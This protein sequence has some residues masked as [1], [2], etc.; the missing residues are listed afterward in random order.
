MAQ[1]KFFDRNTIL[2]VGFILA[3]LLGLALF[4]TC[5][6]PK[7]REVKASVVTSETEV[8]VGSPIIFQDNTEE[9][10]T[11]DWDFGDST[12]HSPDR[13]PQH[14]FS[15][16]GAYNVVLK[17]NG[18]CP[19]YLTVNVLPLVEMVKVDTNLVTGQ[20][21]A[22]ASAYV[23]QVVKFK[24]ASGKGTSWEWS[25]GESGKTDAT[26]KEP[27]Y[28]FKSPGVHEVTL[29]INGTG[30]PVKH[31]I[32]IQPAPAKAGGAKAPNI[33]EAEFKLK[34]KA[35]IAQ[36]LKGAT[37]LSAYIC[38]YVSMPITVNGQQRALSSYCDGL[39]MSGKSVKEINSVKLT[40]D[41]TT[42]C[43]VAIEI[44]Q[45]LKPTEE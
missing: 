28:T 10:K 45:E 42:N 14:I 30:K 34:L 13:T 27:S 31:K 29:M 22:P 44:I 35:I 21:V 25:F 12:A 23:G 15:K 19:G 33:S 16:E 7:C 24:D 41:P 5:S 40:H 17:V 26:E 3:L 36:Q 6:K 32:F 43:I 2:I 4:K 11:W 38:D 20:I 8:R 18:R 37:D 1:R 9:A 39:Y